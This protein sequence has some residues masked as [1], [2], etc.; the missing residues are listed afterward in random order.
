MSQQRANLLTEIVFAKV[1]EQIELLAHIVRQLPAGK[2]DWSPEMPASISPRPKCLGEVLG[3][4]LECLAGLVAVLYAA[5]PEQLGRF[6]DLRQ[7]PVNH[8]CGESEALD[9]IAEYGRYIREGFQLLSDSD[10]ARPLPTV[11]VPEGEPILLLLLGNLE[12]LLNHKHEIFVYG[13]LL[14]VPLT[15]P[16]LYRFRGHSAG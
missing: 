5:H 8:L 4:L 13:K 7:R 2:L 11:F 3:H 10:L 12:H 6:Q 16:D 14:G 15:T 1:D 9:R